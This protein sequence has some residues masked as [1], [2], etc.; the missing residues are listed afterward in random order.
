[1]NINKEISDFLRDAQ[2]KLAKMTSDMDALEDDGDIYYQKLKENRWELDYFYSIL[3]ETGQEMEG[4]YNWL[5]TAGWTL[6]EILNE[7]HYLRKKNQM[8]G[9]PVL[10]YQHTVHQIIAF[11]N[12][13]G[14]SALPVA[15]SAGMILVSTSL[16]GWE[17]ATLGNYVGMLDSE[18]LNTYFTGRT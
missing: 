17:E 3:L 5:E 6:K 13:S 15:S 2:W 10:N 16:G 7:I 14:G 11:I 12:G 8:N 9:M 18:S 1:M 4:G